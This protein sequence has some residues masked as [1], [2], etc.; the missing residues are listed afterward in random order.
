[1]SLRSFFLA[2]AAAALVASA[3]GAQTSVGDD[4]LARVEAGLRNA[5][6]DAVLAGAASRVEIVLFGQGGTYR[7]PQAVHVLRDFFRRYPPDRVAFA[8]GSQSDDG[9]TA[10]GRYWTQ[11]GGAPLTLRVL[12]RPSGDEWA[13]VSIRV[14]QQSIIRTGGR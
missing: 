1:M 4:A 14:E 3:A 7:R 6:A 5:D 11:D 9:R 2:A 8:D 12:H 10:I 13:L